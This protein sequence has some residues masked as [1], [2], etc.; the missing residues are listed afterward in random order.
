MQRA[1]LLTTKTWVALSLMFMGIAWIGQLFA[2]EPA[3][4][5]STFEVILLSFFPTGISISLIISWWK[6]YLIG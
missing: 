3:T 1:L 6:S 5:K 4:F 2:P